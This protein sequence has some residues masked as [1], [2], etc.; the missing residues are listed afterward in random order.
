[1]LRPLITRIGPRIKTIAGWVAFRSGLYRRLLRSRAV[2]VV[3]HRVNDSYPNDPITSSSEEFAGFVR[4]FSRFFEV[5]PLSGLLT[6]L[7]TGDDLGG[8]LAI[9]FDDGYLGNATIAAPILKRHAAPATFF[10][11]T[12][13]IGTDR[14]PDWDKKSN[15]PTR[16]MD[17]DQVRA[18]RN[19][20]HEIGSHT[21]THVDLGATNGQIAREEIAAGRHRVE[22]E[23]TEPSVLFSYPF[24][25]KN[26]LT[27]DN[28]RQVEEL[29]LRCC[30]SAY[31]GTV[32]AGDDPFR[33][34]RTP[35]SR[36]FDSPYHFGFELVTERLE[37]K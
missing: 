11:T 14:V 17:W 18:L 4:F 29:G 2:I 25:G 10:V 1:M 37:Q 28:R 7:A 36:W 16:W 8:K 9:T 32:R 6:A 24:G 20:G 33:L 13:F 12:S 31:G 27:E 35:I 19:E 22:A 23:L 30:V 15:I 34:K 21:A 5:V 3:F 26:N